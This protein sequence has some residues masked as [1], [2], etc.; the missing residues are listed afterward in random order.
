MCPNF[1]VLGVKMAEIFE[2]NAKKNLIKKHEKGGN[3]RPQINR[4]FYT[5]D[6]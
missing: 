1:M 2:K 4:T 5:L 3:R 6:V